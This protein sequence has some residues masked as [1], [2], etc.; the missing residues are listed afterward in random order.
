M[1]GIGAGGLQAL[2]QVIIAALIPPRERGRYSGYLGAV[3]AA[4]TVSGPLVGGLLVDTPA[5]G[6]RWCF[7]VGVPVG[8]DRAGRAAAHPAHP[9]RSQRERLQLDYLGAA[10]IA[11]GVS[12]LLIWI[13]L[14][15]EQFAWGSATSLTLAGLGVAALVA[16]V[17]R[18][19]AGARADGA[20]VAVP[21]P[22]RG[23][24]RAG[25]HGASA[26]SCSAGRC[27]SASTSRSPAATRRPRPGLLTLPLIAGL[28]IA[29]T[30]VRP[31]DQPVRAVEAVPGRRGGPDHRPGWRCSSP[32]T[33]PRRS[34]RSWACTW[35]VLGLGVGMS[36]QNLVLAVQNT[37]DL[38]EVGAASSLVAFLRSMGGTIGVTVLGVVLSE[39]GGRAARRVG[40]AARPACPDLSAARRRC[41][42]SARARGLRRRRSAW[43]SASP[44]VASADLAVAMLPLERRSHLTGDHWSPLRSHR[45]DRPTS[46][47]AGRR[48]SGA[49]GSVR[50][51]GSGSGE[52]ALAQ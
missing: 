25:Q 43:S 8:A 7:F 46:E 29:S 2:A 39:P 4:A 20:D 37:V 11:G 34:R 18:G 51:S 47:P 48:W 22:H 49:P 31:A 13:S 28:L 30:G 23:A 26:W 27:S 44:R 19:A 5:L 40:A 14:A 41:R 9:D 33:T 17:V 42:P 12:T 15:G 38:A 16:A 35:C 32:S 1:Q 3:L 6:W 52:L 36:M 24:G 50:R 10:L 45:R 21:R